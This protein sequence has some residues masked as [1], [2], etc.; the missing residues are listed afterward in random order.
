MVIVVAA[1]GFSAL[2]LCFI[3]ALDRSPLSLPRPAV[4]SHTHYRTTWRHPMAY[5]V[6]TSLSL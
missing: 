1:V 6:L 2:L 4:Y 5:F 3:K